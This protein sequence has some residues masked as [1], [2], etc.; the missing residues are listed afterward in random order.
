MGK[1]G[2]NGLT[3]CIEILG[4]EKSL[5]RCR[6]SKPLELLHMPTSLIIHFVKDN[7]IFLAK[8]PGGTHAR[9]Q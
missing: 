6:T 9:A 7:V 3:E 2:M 1:L 5:I 4:T 8:G